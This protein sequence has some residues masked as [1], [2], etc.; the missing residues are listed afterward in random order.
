M[1]LKED[2]VST[3]IKNWNEVVKAN[4]EKTPITIKLYIKDKWWKK[5]IPMP[6]YKLF[7]KPDEVY[8]NCYPAQIGEE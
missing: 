1:A 4:K 6:I 3:F 5:I 8:K 2:L 7:F